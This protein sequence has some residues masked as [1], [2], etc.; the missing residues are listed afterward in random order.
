MEAINAQLYAFFV[1]IVGGAIVGILVDLYRIIR[2]IVRPGRF[3]T[4][5]GD[6][7]FP[8]L[9]GMT[10]YLFLLFKNYGEVRGY[11]FIGVIVGLYIYKTTLSPFL[12]RSFVASRILYWRVLRKV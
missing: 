6:L 9:C 4:E 2:R 5:L 7:I 11:V 12:L 1:T 3:L 10:L 8:I